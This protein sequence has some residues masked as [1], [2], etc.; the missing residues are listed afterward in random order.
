MNTHDLRFGSAWRWIK[1][2]AN[3]G[4]SSPA[5]RRQARRV[6]SLALLI[7]A[8]AANTR[9]AVTDGL[10]AYWRFDETNGLAAADSTTNANSGALNSFPADNSQ[11]VAGKIGGALNF[12]GPGPNEYVRVPKYPKLSGAMSVSA[13][14]WADARPSWASILKNWGGSAAGQFH[15]GLQ[16]NAGD[17]SNFLQ[18]EGGVFPNARE[19][20]PFP[21]GSWQHV[22]LTA[23]GSTLR[24]YRNGTEVGSAAY[25]GNL[26]NSPMAALG[27]GVKLND[28]GTGPDTGSPGFWQGRMDDLGLWN[29]A[30][31]VGEVLAIYGAGLNGQSLSSA[32][33]PP[34]TNGLVSITEF[35]AQ[36][37]GALKDADGDSPDWIEIHNGTAA[38]VNLAN[39]SLTD[40]TNNLRQ[41][42]FPATNLASGAYLVVFASGKIPSVRNGELHANFSLS[43]GGEYLALVDANTNIVSQFA[44]TFPTQAP[45]VS[46]GFAAFAPPQN[47]LTNGTSLRWLVPTND[48]LGTNWILPGFDDSAWEAGSNFVGYET[49]P[50]NYAGLFRTD[51]GAQMFN[52][53]P[54]VY[55]R[56]P[57]VVT[58][59]LDFADWTLRLQCDDGCVMW[60]NGEEILRYYVPDQ[61]AWN[62]F[63]T[64]NRADGDV[65]VGE[66]YDL[67]EFEPLLVP[68]TNWLVIHALNARLDSSD[69]LVAPT[70]AARSTLQLAASQ[71]YFATPTPGSANVGGVEVLG[72]ILSELAHTPAVPTDTQDL[73]VT[74]RVRQAFGAVTNVTLNYRVMYSNEVATPMFD[75]GAHG[76]GLPGDG[77]FGATIPASASDPGQMVRYRVTALDAT[78]RDSREPL[79]IDPAGSPE[80]QGTMIPDPSITTPLPVFHWFVQ[81]P[82]AATAATGTRSSLFYDGE[83]YDNIFVRLRGGTSRGAPKKSYKVEFNEGFHF[84]LRDGQARVS[85]FDWNTTYT[86]KSYNRKVIAYEGYRDAGQ[87]VIETFHAHLRQNGAFYSVALWTEQPDRDFLRRWGLDADGAFYKAGFNGGAN[88]TYETVTAFEKKTRL[89]EG[90]ADLQALINGL[91]L[92]G[93]A[94]ENFLFDN[95]DLPGMVN[96]TAIVAV[97]QNIDASDKNHYVYRDTLGTREWRV[98]P[99]DLDLTFGPDSLNTDNIVFNQQNTNTPYAPSHPFIG[100]RPYMLH[101]TKYNRFIE[102]IVNVPRT[103]EMLLRRIRT[104]AEE[105]LVS[106]Y[107]ARRIDQLVALLGPDVSADRARWGSS[108]HFPGGTYTLQ[109]ANDRIKNE[110]LTPRVG[111]LTGSGIAGVG[112]ANPGPQPPFIHVQFHSLDVNPASGNQQQEYICVTNPNPVA[113]DLTGWRVRGDVEFDF[114]PATVMTSNSVMYLSPNVTE[115]RARNAGPRGG[116]GLFVQGNYQGNL[117][118]RGGSLQLIDRWGRT[119]QTLGHPAAPSLAQQFLRITEIMYHP[120]P[121]AGNTNSAEEFEFIELQ[122][123]SPTQALDLT[124]IRFI[125]GIEFNFAGS[126]VTTLAAN[127][128]VLIVKNPAAFAARYGSGLPVAGGFTGSLDNSGER[129]RLV[130]ARGEEILDF[131]YENGWHPITD[132]HGFSLVIADATAAFDT[133]GRKTSWRASGALGGSPGAS[134]P[135]P[136]ALAPIVIN[137]AL[138]RTDVAPPTD[139]IELFNPTAT[140]VNIGGWFLSDAF[141]TPKKFRIPDATTI[142]AG[143]YAV[144]TEAQFNPLGA[145][146]ALGSDGGQVWLFSADAN[147]NLTG[148]VH[149]FRFGA[150]ENGVT[151]GRH[152]TSTGDE[153]F[154]AQ[155]FVTLNALNSGPRIGPVVITE[156]MFHPPDLGTNDNSAD[157]FIELLNLTAGTVQLFDP[158]NAA[159]TWKLSGSADFTFPT[160]KS[161]APG[162]RLLLVNFNPTTDPAALVAFRAKYSVGPSVQLFGPYSGKLDNSGGD[163]ELKKPAT[164]LPSGVPYVIVDKVDYNDSTPWPGADGD[165]T[166]LQRRSANAYGNDPA[167]WVAAAPG[168]AAPYATGGVPVITA[169]PTGQSVVAFQ[170]ATFTVIANGDG[171][172]R[173]QWRHNGINLIN[174]TN[175]AL[176]LTNI[177]Y[178]QLGSYDVS[179]FNGSGSAWSSNAL[180]T[181]IVAPIILQ[182]PQSLTVLSGASATFTV[183]ATGTG[184][185]AYQW[186]R[187][188]ANIPGATNASFTLSNLLPANSGVIT[189]VIS[190]DIG[191]IVSAPAVLSVLDSPVIVSGPT[192]VFQEALQGATFNIAVTATGTP[193]L[194]YRWRRNNITVLNQTNA[195]LRVT[196]AASA[197][198]GNYT[199]IVTNNAGAVTSVVAVVTFAPDFDR[200]GLSDNWERLHGFNTN[201]V[202]DAAEDA[203]G[204]GM[205]NWQ[206]YVAGTNPTNALSYL[207][208]DTLTARPA[209]LGFLAVSNRTYTVR[210]SDRVAGGQWQ[211]L[212]HVPARATN[213]L[214]LIPD[215]AYATNRFYRV[216]TPQQP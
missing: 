73:L 120:A 75:D 216:V 174:G 202:A 165:G 38:A 3:L 103:R 175:A 114:K 159:N 177:Q 112:A 16:D 53:A 206:E 134:E 211:T 204:D 94:L 157:E 133:W 139:T 105:Q 101:A 36:N 113:V 183:A 209:T 164:P 161:L 205:L 74:V 39:W 201:L 5:R 79:F 14:V 168:A 48:A 35:M 92:P 203:D 9:A 40:R 158:A 193:P 143:S 171:P 23:D 130:D 121:L 189:V 46:Y 56:I 119:V 58:N 126:A 17:L 24:L 148:R 100:A 180:L 34:A 41:W 31:S 84:R 198:A 88:A 131:D 8:G 64:T 80:Y 141:N 195:L 65:L 111:Y 96:V 43:A 91:A 116:Q 106:G 11:W 49:S 45:N 33:A 176:M 59:P 76:D 122:N 21:L 170:S 95:V 214:E 50:E 152:V 13:W 4:H 117:S 86:D 83:F 178:S 207:K 2:G 123:T 78:G 44:P 191:S 98:L 194:S 97:Q 25:V 160:N 182:Q 109:Q 57:F 132:G 63:S 32:D 179:V 154:V 108:A 149:G 104:L 90:S 215:P 200:D 102:A 89:T 30:L 129:L 87:P 47:F 153:H 173:Y 188:G 37:N 145:G 135:T 99:W 156:I 19:N 172:L 124:G 77:L 147:T 125:S 196:N 142:G 22:A 137:E 184:T 42:L 210:F 18:T 85:E 151:F 51:V 12:R 128:R 166:S 187:D 140:N 1:L 7:I 52:R 169:Q 190:D 162:E 136:P 181:I 68:G 93:V 167:N 60:L 192:P 146:F 213:R 127:A 72:P 69:L 144:F 81:N 185:L 155:T 66:T 199:V 27:I 150:A 62:S 28:A 186:R 6:V 70:I 197:N 61:L 115:F 82:T 55:I 29:R 118:A 10:V 107:Y 208:I 15:F 54:S 110:Y 212:A 26:A 67:A 20:T 163:V 138:T 71:R